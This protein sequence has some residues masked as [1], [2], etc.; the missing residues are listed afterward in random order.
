MTPNEQSSLEKGDYISPPSSST[1]PLATTTFPST[2]SITVPLNTTREYTRNNVYSN[3]PY[4]D[5][6]S[7][8]YWVDIEHGEFL[9]GPERLKS[10]TVQVEPLTKEPSENDIVIT[11]PATSDNNVR[12][13]REFFLNS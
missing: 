13:L 4:M 1:N 9:K 7:K 8:R 5:T 2:H 10:T 11:N 6:R 3:M 12:K